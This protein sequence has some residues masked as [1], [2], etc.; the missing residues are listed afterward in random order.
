MTWAKSRQTASPTMRSANATD[1]PQ[2]LRRSRL[3]VR[4]PPRDTDPRCR[5]TLAVPVRLGPYDD[6]RAS[7][8]DLG[9]AEVEESGMIRN[10]APGRRSRRRDR[11]GRLRRLGRRLGVRSSGRVPGR[12]FR[13]LRRPRDFFRGVADLG[14]RNT[15]TNRWSLSENRT[16]RQKEQ[17]NCPGRPHY[18]NY[19]H[20]E[21]LS[22]RVVSRKATALLIYPEF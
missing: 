8:A 13:G 1:R 9:L 10:P 15:R 2:S 14:R 16:C 19:P 5:K 17:K 22:R 21:V 12:R 3:P 20:D 6:C 18:P 11:D 7:I 4:H